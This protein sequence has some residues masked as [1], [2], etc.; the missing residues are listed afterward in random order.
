MNKVNHLKVIPKR[1]QASKK[2]KRMKLSM[3]LALSVFFIVLTVE[4]VLI[5]HSNFINKKLFNE[6]IEGDLTTIA[7]INSNHAGIL[8][9]E[10]REMINLLAE[11]DSIQEL[12]EEAQKRELTQD[13]KAQLSNDLIEIS[14]TAHDFKEIYVVGL[15]GRI[16]M[17]NNVGSVGGKM[18]VAEDFLAGGEDTGISKIYYSDFLKKNVIYIY[19]NIIDNHE[20][21][22]MHGALIGTLSLKEFAGIVSSEGLGETGESYV[23]NSEG[24]FITPSRFLRGDNMGVLTQQINTENYKE[25]F[26]HK[27]QGV[28]KH[29]VYNNYFDYRGEDVIGTHIPIPE[30]EWCLIAKIDNDEI[31]EVPRNVFLKNEVTVAAIILIFMTLLFFNFGR[32]IDKRVKIGRVR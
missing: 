31:F 24:F 30:S 27:T 13:E 32:F 28:I 17:S 21:H 20:E 4:L 18:S 23:V 12:V 6:R 9:L 19:S 1:A 14:K 26:I 22:K 3:I 11:R 10:H 7:K 8:L 25:C 2:I 29:P 16:I 5:G 15:D